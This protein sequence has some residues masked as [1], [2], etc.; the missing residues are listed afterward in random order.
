[1]NIKIVV[2]LA[3]LIAA[4]T[5]WFLLPHIAQAAATLGVTKADQTAFP[6]PQYVAP[7]TTT[8]KHLQP[9][10]I[11]WLARLMVCESG[12]KVTAINPN[13]LDNTPSY[14]LLQFK[15]STYAAAAKKYGLASTMD[16]M[17]PEG[18]VAIVEQWILDG[19]VT[20]GKQF[21]DCVRK[22]GSPPPLK[23]K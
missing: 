8:P 17:N 15:P 5:T 11:I 4:L 21:P 18:Q 3:A 6:N 23:K 19:S 14:G 9:A 1:M 22:L 10:Q 7:A 20:W 2:V 13:D 12:L 16:Y